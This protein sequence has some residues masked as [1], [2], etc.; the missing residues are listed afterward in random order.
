LWPAIASALRLQHG[1]RSELGSKDTVLVT[2]SGRIGP[3]RVDE[4]SH[5]DLKEQAGCDQNGVPG[6]GVVDCVD[7]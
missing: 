7:R 5:A 2:P 4:S 6:C 1:R 3:L